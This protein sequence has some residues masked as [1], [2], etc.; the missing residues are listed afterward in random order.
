[1]RGSR[2]AA[3]EADRCKIMMFVSSCVYLAAAGMITVNV[4]MIW[5]K[6]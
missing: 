2:D 6:N 5:L 4:L 1:M 3:L